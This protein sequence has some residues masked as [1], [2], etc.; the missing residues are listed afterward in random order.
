MVTEVA[1]DAL[2]HSLLVGEVPFS[3]WNAS[4][5]AWADFSSAATMVDHD[6]VF[7]SPS[8]CSAT[9]PTWAPALKAIRTDSTAKGSN[10]VSESAEATA[11]AAIK[12]VHRPTRRASAL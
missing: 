3:L 11:E 12:P 8:I 1:E 6:P 4:K 10:A 9:F 2:I 5:A 7:E